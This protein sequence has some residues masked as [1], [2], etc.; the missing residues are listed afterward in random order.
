MIQSH[1]LYRHWATLGA[2]VTIGTLAFDPFLQSVISLK[3]RLDVALLENS[4]TIGRSTSTD[5]G[6][7][8]FA[9]ASSIYNGFYNSTSF[10]SQTVGFRCTTGNC[11]WPVFS[12]L[13]VCSSCVNVSDH[14][15]NRSYESGTFSRTIYSLPYAQI[16]NDNGRKGDGLLD[17]TE[18]FVNSTV[19]PQNT[20]SFTDKDTLLISFLAMLGAPGW[21]SNESNWNESKPDAYECALLLCANAY[22]SKVQDGVLEEQIVGSWSQRNPASYRP[23]NSYDNA[24]ELAVSEAALGSSLYKV[25]DNLTIE[26]TPLQLMIPDQESAFLPKNETRVFNF[27]SVDVI[28]TI[29]FLRQVSDQQQTWPRFGNRNT[30]PSVPEVLGRSTN[31]TLTFEHVAKSITDQIRDLAAS[32]VSGT[33][34]QWQTHVYIFWGKFAIPGFMIVMGCVY[35]V[36]TIIQSRRLD[37]P[38][39]KEDTLPTLLHGFDDDSQTLLRDV[40]DDPK[41]DRAAEGVLVQFCKEKNRLRI[42]SKHDCS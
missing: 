42:I 22:I 25:Y 5:F 29:D 21:R 30:G 4:V 17:Q 16:T 13:A 31:I 12:T 20:I 27:T 14:I 32:S 9:I 26:R 41:A 40:Q 11:T 1:T 2:L 38:A 24:T 34:Y 37:L 18:I 35:V 8:D 10:R 36:L 6:A 15:Q 23:L 33:A 39:W 28:S 19:H 3:G 7:A